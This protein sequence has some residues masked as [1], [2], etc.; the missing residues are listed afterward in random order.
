MIFKLIVLFVDIKLDGCYYVPP[1]CIPP[2]ASMNSSTEILNPFAPEVFMPPDTAAQAEVSRD[3]IALTLGVRIREF[4]NICLVGLTLYQFY[5]LGYGTFQSAFL[6]KF[7]Y[8][9]NILSQQM[10]LFIS[11]HGMCTSYYFYSSLVD[12]FQV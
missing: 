9:E 10:T 12:C 6:Q 11:Y 1:S 2:F 4:Y 8:G 5:R 7:A 3:I